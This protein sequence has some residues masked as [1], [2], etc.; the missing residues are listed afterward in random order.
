MK[1]GFFYLCGCFARGVFGCGTMYLVNEYLLAQGI[2]YIVGIN[3]YTIGVSAFLGL[4]GLISMYLI[5]L[6]DI[7]KL[8]WV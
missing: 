4:P 2:T 8:N 3:T 5:Q 1:R 7:I 6:S